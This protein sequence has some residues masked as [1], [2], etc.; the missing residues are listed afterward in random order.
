M[1]IDTTK[2]WN[3]RI[4]DLSISQWFMPDDKILYHYTSVDALFGGII[5][6]NKPEPG[7][8]ICLWATNCRYMNDP[9]EFSTGIRLAHEM[10]D[11]PSN[12]SIQATSEQIKENIY[13]ISFSSAV[14]CLP[15]WGMYGQNGHGLALGFDTAVLKTFF[16]LFRCAYATEKNKKWLKEEISKLTYVPND[17]RDQ[18][19]GENMLSK[20]IES[21]GEQLGVYI[22]LWILGKH[23]AYEYEK[24][25]RAIFH[26]RKNAHSQD[27]HDSSKSD[28][29]AIKYRL[30]NN[31]IVP[32]VELYLPKSALKEIWIG[33]TND[34]E[35]ATKSLRTYL[36]YMGFNEVEIKQS[37]IPYRD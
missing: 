18:P 33:P 8:E 12:E 13:I 3:L 1:K 27:T 31:L 17:W 25:E 29:E 28:K 2:D 14:D 6:K 23:P 19:E 9:K 34:M 20:I 21:F 10:L 35:R 37:K 15:M 36:D 4:E 32:Y 16:R 26:I 24:E 5:V 22:L 7:K 30:K 11:I